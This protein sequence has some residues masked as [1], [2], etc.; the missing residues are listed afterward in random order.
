MRRASFWIV[1]FAVIAL[2]A[3]Y[4]NA[5]PNSPYFVYVKATNED[6]S[7]PS[8]TDITIE[9]TDANG[10]TAT[11]QSGNDPDGIISYDDSA[12]II[13][14]SVGNFTEAWSD[15][16]EIAISITTTTGGTKQVVTNIDGPAGYVGP[17]TD[18]DLT[19][20]NV[21]IPSG[22]NTKPVANAANFTT[23]V[24]GTLN[25]LLSGSDADPDDVL[26]FAKASDP[27]SGSVTVNEDGTFTYEP[28][29]GFEGEDSFQ[30]TVNDGTENSD[31]AT[32]TITVGDQNT[33]PVA[34]NGEF[35]TVKNEE[36]ADNLSATDADGDDLSYSKVSD[37]TH[38]SVTINSADGSFTYMPQTDYVG[39]DS[40]QFK[41]N[42]GKADSNTATVTITVTDTDEPVASPDTLEVKR[43]MSTDGKL[44]ATDPKGT[45]TLT[46]SI[47]TD[48]TQGSITALDDAAG[49]YTYA[50]T[51]TTYVGPDSFTFKANDGT[52]DSNIATVSI[53]I[54]CVKGDVNALG[55][56]NTDPVDIFDA[57]IVAEYDA[58]LKTQEELPCFGSADVDGIEGVTIYDALAIAIYVATG[59]WQ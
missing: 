10:Q 37:P 30:F 9:A 48:P 20:E 35:S 27:S 6:G 28:N 3:G 34:N 5:G 50:P 33:A 2:A 38:G 52:D 31:P 51:D 4:A 14:I 44:S 39:G 49:T 41:V 18:P 11:Y 16:D 23:P 40:F 17:D 45:E 7:F 26:T 12:G 43:G 21:D 57:L 1:L 22:G 59:D 24:N 8:A 47:V 54:S 46:Y 25:N 56:V 32:V 15:G 29:T 53:N 42:D 13:T 19:I 58:T 55:D 36:L